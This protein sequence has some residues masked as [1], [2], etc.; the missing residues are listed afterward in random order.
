M[1]FLQF[2]LVGTILI[3]ISG[4]VLFIFGVILYKSWEALEDE[5]FYARWIIPAAL[6]IFVMY[7]QWSTNFGTKYG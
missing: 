1:E 6:F 4:F 3:L 7:L 2:L 5:P